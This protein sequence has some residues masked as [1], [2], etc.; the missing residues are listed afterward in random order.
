M[1]QA[2]RAV[3]AIAGAAAKFMWALGCGFRPAAH[4]A[5]FGI[6]RSDFLFQTPLKLMVGLEMLLF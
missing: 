6:N 3:P 2:D 4:F 1:S 5:L